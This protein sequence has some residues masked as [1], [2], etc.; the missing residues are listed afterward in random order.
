MRPFIEDKTIRQKFIETAL[1]KSLM[2]GK[3]CAFSL[4]ASM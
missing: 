3:S 2:P 1:S 4:F